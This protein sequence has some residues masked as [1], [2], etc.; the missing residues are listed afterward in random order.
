MRW[1]RSCPSCSRTG[2]SHHGPHPREDLGETVMLEA[3]NEVGGDPDQV[4]IPVSRRSLRRVLT[5]VDRQ[6][7]EALTDEE[8]HAL[9]AAV[10]AALDKRIPESALV[11]TVARD[12]LE[13]RAS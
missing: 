1:P 2:K 3:G 8:W 7:T 12:F 6:A 9:A 4:T 11:R 10:G 5:A 13:R